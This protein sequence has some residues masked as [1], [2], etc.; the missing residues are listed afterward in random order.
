M[1]SEVLKIQPGSA[2][3]DS[4]RMLGEI[5]D[6]AR[7]LVEDMSD[8]VW[9][10]DPRRD[11]LG[12]LIARL[13]AF[14]FSV[15]E[16]RGIRWTFEVPEESLS[17]RLSP[18]QRRQLYLILKEALHNIA[19]H[20]QAATAAVRIGF[21]GRW[22]RGEIDALIP[23]NVVP[24][25]RTGD[26]RIRR[27]FRN[28][29]E[30]VNEYFRRT[31]I[32]PITH[33]LVVRQS[34]FEK[35]PW[36]VASLLDAFTKAE[37]LCRKSYD[38]AK[39]L[40]FPSAVLILEEEEELFGDNPW[41]HGLTPQNRVVLEKFIQYAHE[42]GYIPRRPP[43][44]ELQ[45]GANFIP[46]HIGPRDPHEPH[47]QATFLELFFDLCFVVAVAYTGA[48]LHHAV[49]EGHLAAGLASYLTVFFA[50]WWGWMNFS[51]FSSA[52]DNDDGVHRL[53]T[54]VQI[55]GALI[56]AA[57]VPR[58][59]EIRQ[60]DVVFV[61]YLFMRAGLGFLWLRAARADPAC[62]QTCNRYALGITAAMLGWS[63]ML[64]AGEWP[65]WGWWLMAFVELAVPAWAEWKVTTPWHPHHIAERYG[66]FTIIVLGESV[67][68]ATN[69]VREG[70]E[71]R[72]FSAPLLGLI[73]GG[74]VVV[75]T[76]WW[77]Y[78]AKPAHRFLTSNRVAFVW[79]YGHYFIFCAAAAVGAGLAVNV[80]HILGA[81]TIDR[82]LAA[83]AVSVP[84]ALFLLTVWLLHVRPHHAR[85]GLSF[86]FPVAIAGVLLATLCPWPVPSIAVVM[87]AFLGTELWLADRRYGREAAA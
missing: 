84:V 8:I 40:A 57:G 12:D 58:A 52:Y 72:G 7:S 4:S 79:G 20:S 11:K 15:L 14:G 28:I 27:V 24:S 48:E 63:V 43:L 74:L 23:P 87:T 3:L 49:A 45:S 53:A 66:L 81:T 78:F 55:A 59:F 29:R 42:Q 13:R 30:T 10:I 41:G 31:G 22:L 70:V 68:A 56:M 6:T 25:F 46:R 32:F 18:D 38:Y 61:G 86:L 19:R 64:V 34:L 82:R 76:L 50:I 33:T 5:A 36:I 2:N 51:W 85:L 54:M 80:D 26:P 83:A 71:G 39:R 21:D 75:F 1:I 47:R 9:S 77:V 73:A 16:P 62:R 65:L 69:A 37:E 44:A 60:F 35:N 67:L 17:R